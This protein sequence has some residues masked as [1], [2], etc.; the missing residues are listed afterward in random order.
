MHDLSSELYVGKVDDRELVQIIAPLFGSGLQQS[1]NEVVYYRQ[2]E[3]HALKLI[4]E[5]NR[6]QS[7]Q[8]GPGLRPEDVR[9]LREKAQ[10]DLVAPSA[11]LV[12]RAVLFSSYPVTGYFEADGMFQILPVP[13]EAPK[14]SYSMAPHPFLIEF[15]FNGSPNFQVRLARRFRESHKLALFLNVVLEGTITNPGPTHRAYWV[16]VSH[17]PG[18]PAKYDYCQGGYGYEGLNLESKA[19]SP[20]NDLEPMKQVDHVVYFKR[21]GIEVGRSLEVPKSMLQLV[22]QHRGLGVETREQFL[23]AA[24]WYRHAIVEHSDSGSASFL[25]LINSIEALVPDEK[26]ATVC[27]ECK[28]SIGKSMTQR[29]VE[30]LEDIVPGTGNVESA[31]RNLYRVRGKLTHGGDL[32]RVDLDPWPA[33]LH[34]EL[35]SEREDTSHAYGLARAALVNWLARQGRERTGVRS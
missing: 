1:E 7:I 21:W 3:P 9:A 28:R 27:P 16:L 34:L 35:T 20:L 10:V 12:G 25:A 2:G 17:E 8:A 26:G 14:P 19:F 33:G 15:R 31:R 18:Q 13:P 5:D 6:L 4:Y 29:F 24:F 30:F 22:E 23:R 11:A 32:L